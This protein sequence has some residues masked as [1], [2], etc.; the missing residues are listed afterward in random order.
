MNLFKILCLFLAPTITLN[1]QSLKLKDQSGKD[2]AGDT[3]AVVFHPGPNHGWT[4]LSIFIYPLNI[5]D[6]ALTVGLKKTEYNMH[7]DEYHAFCF[8]GS[9]YDSTTFVSP[10]NIF[11]ES[12]KMD[13]SFSG[14]YRFDDLLHM[15]NECLVAY[16]FFN[17]NNTADSAI[18][19]VNY[20][21]KLHLVGIQNHLESNKISSKA[22]P[23]PAN[24]ML[25][26]NY[27]FNTNV[28]SNYLTIIISNSLGEIICKQIISPNNNIVSFETKDW[29]PGFYY[30]S[31]VSGNGSIPTG[32]FVITH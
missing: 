14:H 31:V 26:M 2:V 16:T 12:G 10:Y 25:Y 7:F 3:L 8:G 15:P 13:S 9:C 28:F 22:W 27:Q 24:E 30:Y 1:A 18:V 5:S 29:S 6:S 23:N 4:E 32:K 19:Y 21:T 11:L 20:N 17:A